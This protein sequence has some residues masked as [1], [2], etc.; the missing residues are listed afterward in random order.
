MKQATDKQAKKPVDDSFAP[1]KFFNLKQKDVMDWK[2]TLAAVK[3]KENDT[4]LPQKRLR[5]PELTN[6]AEDLSRNKISVD[7]YRNLVDKLMPI[8]PFKQVPEMT[9]LIDVVRSL[10]AGKIKEGV[11]VI[12]KRYSKY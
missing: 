1:Y 12:D 6:A 8:V 11:G 10:N 3:I 4:G 9:S 7:E 5:I 2:E